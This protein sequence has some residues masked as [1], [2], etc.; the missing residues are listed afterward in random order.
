MRVGQ[1]QRIQLLETFGTNSRSFSFS[2]IAIRR[3][4]DTSPASLPHESGPPPRAQIPSSPSTSAS[5]SSEPITSSPLA[6]TSIPSSTKRGH[7]RT[8]S[9][10]TLGLGENN[11]FARRSTSGSLRHEGEEQGGTIVGRAVNIANTAKDL[12][13]ALWSYGSQQDTQQTRSQEIQGGD[14]SGPNKKMG[15]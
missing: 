13:G 2:Q 3:M 7:T 10:P 6:S 14:E 15:R 4:V 12:L 5:H 9:L 1:M 11:I 8:P